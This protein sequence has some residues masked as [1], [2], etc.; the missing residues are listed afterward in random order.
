MEKQVQEFVVAKTHDLMDAPSCCPEAK[1][2]AQAW[3]NA[4]GTANEAAETQKYLK[5]LEEDIT[6]IDGLI[7][8]ANSPAAAKAFGAEGAK[9][10]AA[11][12]AEI[13]AAGAKYCDC[14]AC[15]AALAILEKKDSL[16]H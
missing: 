11:H 12:A 6:S 15:V 10:F 5:E 4:I 3:L 14:P 8:F 2:A 16:L 7:A 9:K 13:K 1:A